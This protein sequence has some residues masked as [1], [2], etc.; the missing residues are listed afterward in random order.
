MLQAGRPGQ[1]VMQPGACASPANRTGPKPSTA[2][3]DRR[4]RRR[5]PPESVDA[6]RARS[7]GVPSDDRPDARRAFDSSIRL[8]GAHQRKSP[9]K[10]CVSRAAGTSRHPLAF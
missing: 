4:T 9:T 10:S 6:E 3:L 5:P 7:E 8:A 2:G 1:R